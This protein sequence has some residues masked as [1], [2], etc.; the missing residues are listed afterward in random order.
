[1]FAKHRADRR[2]S[3]I[4]IL[5][6]LSKRAAM[7]VPHA[8]LEIPLRESGHRRIEIGQIVMNHRDQ[9]IE[10]GCRTAKIRI[11]IVVTHAPRQI[12]ADDGRDQCRDFSTESG[13]LIGIGHRFPGLAVAILHTLAGAVRCLDH[14][15][16]P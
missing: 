10:N 13:F 6:Q 16:R 14:A 7:F 2:Q 9:F 12:T 15:H 3:Q 8:G 4:E 5:L 1:M 11:R